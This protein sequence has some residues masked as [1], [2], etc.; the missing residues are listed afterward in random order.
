MVQDGRD[1][2]GVTGEDERNV[3]CRLAEVPERDET[4]GRT[5]GEEVGRGHLRER[6]QYLVA[7]LVVH[8]K[9]KWNQQYEQNATRTVAQLT[10]LADSAATV[11]S[12]LR[13][14]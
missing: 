11:K 7:G 5:G 9:G 13:T 1:G 6:K 3:L 8:R 12:Q 10:L 2:T 14:V 4:I